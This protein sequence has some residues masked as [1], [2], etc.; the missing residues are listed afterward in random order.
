M[1]TARIHVFGAAG[2]GVTTLAKASADHLGH[3]YLDADDYLW[4]PTEPSYREKRPVEARVGLL[5]WDTPTSAWVLGGSLITWG[6]PV[7]PRF[8]LAVFVTLD[9]AVVVL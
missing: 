7:I 9:K 8:T 3:R 5:L 1:T 4:T 6:D 2:T